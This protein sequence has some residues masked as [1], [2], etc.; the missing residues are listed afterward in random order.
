MR[1][2]FVDRVTAFEPWLRIAGRKAVSLEEYKL[3]RPFGREGVLPETLV[4]ECCVEHLRWLIAASSGF[5]QACVLEEV[6]S[7]AFSTPAGMG[8]VLEVDVRL[9][10]PGRVPAGEPSP[11]RSLEAECRVRA[12]GVEVAS[13]RIRAGLVPLADGFDPGFVQGLWKDLHGQA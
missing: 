4:L 12:V 7:F 13:G 2:R 9:T 11:E 10:G 8:A 3:L 6:V 1:W 5:R